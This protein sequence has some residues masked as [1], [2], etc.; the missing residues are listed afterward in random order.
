MNEYIK[1]KISKICIKNTYIK[2][3]TA[4]KQLNSIEKSDASYIIDRLMQT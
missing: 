1:N 4:C 3:Y 2:I